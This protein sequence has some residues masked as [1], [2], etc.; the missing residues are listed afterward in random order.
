MPQYPYHPSIQN[1]G[2]NTPSSILAPCFAEHFPG[3]AAPGTPIMLEWSRGY[4]TFRNGIVACIFPYILVDGCFYPAE[5][6][7]PTE[8]TGHQCGRSQTFPPATAWSGPTCE[9]LPH[10]QLHSPLHADTAW[11]PHIAPSPGKGCL[12]CPNPCLSSIFSLS[13]LFSS[14]A[15]RERAGR[16]WEQ[17]GDVV[18]AAAHPA[19]AATTAPLI[20]CRGLRVRNK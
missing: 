20:H 19:P 7:E 10:S 4:P 3:R 2:F 18:D 11:P 1:V 6:A 8:H 15:G 14:E 9:T 12:A 16:A 5:G 17:A 13:S